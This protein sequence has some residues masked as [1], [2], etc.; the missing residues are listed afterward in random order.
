MD[1]SI[2]YGKINDFGL[3]VA[4]P[5]TSAPIAGSPGMFKNLRGVWHLSASVRDDLSGIDDAGSWIEWNGITGVTEYDAEKARLIFKH[6]QLKPG[7]GKP[8]SITVTDRSGNRR[9]FSYKTR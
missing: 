5:D 2:L 4:M 8:V 6:P 7:A 9:V 1:G 3:H